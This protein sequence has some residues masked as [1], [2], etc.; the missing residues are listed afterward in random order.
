MAVT[1]SSKSENIPHTN[2][3]QD[4]FK[5]EAKVMETSDSMVWECKIFTHEFIGFR[6]T[7][8]NYMKLKINVSFMD[9]PLSSKSYNSPHTN[10][11]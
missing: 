3:I 4:S 7:E 5:I 1:N 6:A 9:F 8:N 2:M 10:L 11:L